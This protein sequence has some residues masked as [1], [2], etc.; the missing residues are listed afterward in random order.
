MQENS[1]SCKKGRENILELGKSLEFK[2]CENHAWTIAVLFRKQDLFDISTEIFMRPKCSVF[3]TVC[4]DYKP[5][6]RKSHDRQNWRVGGPEKEYPVINL[7]KYRKKA[8]CLHF[9]QFVTTLRVK[10]VN[11]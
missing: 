10:N 2:A 6:H 3:L 4:K 9:Y 7:C 1:I 8:V 11:K 5:F